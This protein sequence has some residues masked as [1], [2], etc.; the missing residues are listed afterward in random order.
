VSVRCFWT[1]SEDAQL[2]ARYPTT[3]TEKIASQLGRS[4]SS[5]YQRAYK[6]GLSKSVEYL[7][8]PEASRLRRGDNIGAAY[9]FVKGQTPPNKGLRRPGWAPGRMAHTQFRKGERRGV[10]VK[11]Y[12]PIGA[13]RMSKDGYLERKVNDDF[14]AGRRWRA[15]H[16]IV[17]EEANG[18]LQRGRA[19]VFRNGNKTDIRLD[20]MELI[21][22]A[23]LMRRNSVHNLPAPLPQMVQLLGALNRK[24]NRKNRHDEEQNR[25]SKESPVRSVRRA[26]RQGESNGDRTRESDRRCGARDRGLGESGSGVPKRDRPAPRNGVHRS[27]RGSGSAEPSSPR[28]KHALVADGA[29]VGGAA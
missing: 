19:V 1:A 20:N 22:R 12:K 7:A 11:L 18:P 29:V 26:G 21:S 2:T 17:W 28:S 6:L 15:V 14:P 9:R 3:P 13:E 27:T 24:I 10:A 5:T 23:D 16:L 25:G 4:Q 8:S